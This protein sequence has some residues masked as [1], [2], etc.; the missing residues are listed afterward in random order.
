MPGKTKQNKKQLKKKSEYKKGG[1]LETPSD[2]NPC[3]SN[4]RMV[5]VKRV[6]EKR[7]SQYLNQDNNSY[8]LNAGE[9]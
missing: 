1:W 4:H 2:A 7:Y 3:H 6:I 5:G 8:I 9:P